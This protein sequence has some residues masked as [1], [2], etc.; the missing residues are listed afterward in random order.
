M[1]RHLR[2]VAGTPSAEELAALLV[3][4]G[5]GRQGSQ[6]RLAPQTSSAWARAARKEALGARP[7]S[8]PQDLLDPA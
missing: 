4:L 3:A 6:S 2:V 1:I 8:G 7:V 5:E